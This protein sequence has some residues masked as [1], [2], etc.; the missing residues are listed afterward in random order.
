MA[1]YRLLFEASGR[2]FDSRHLHMDYETL[3]N[4]WMKV[5][6]DKKGSVTES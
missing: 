6:R 5:I 2:G 1:V 4:K 3:M